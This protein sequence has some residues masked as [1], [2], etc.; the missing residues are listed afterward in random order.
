M[1]LELAGALHVPMSLM[2]WTLGGRY[3]EAYVSVR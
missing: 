2:S 1:F 3:I